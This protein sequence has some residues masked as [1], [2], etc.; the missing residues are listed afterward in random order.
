MGANVTKDMRIPGCGAIVNNDSARTAGDIHTEPLPPILH[1]PV[2]HNTNRIVND[3]LRDTLR[4]AA[5]SP[6]L[7]QYFEHMRNGASIHKIKRLVD[8]ATPRDYSTYLHDIAPNLDAWSQTTFAKNIPADVREIITNM[9]LEC[10]D[11]AKE[12]TITSRMI[13][14]EYNYEIKKIV[15]KWEYPRDA[16]SRV[17]VLSERPNIALIE[18]GDDFNCITFTWE[19]SQ[20]GQ[21]NGFSTRISHRQMLARHKNN[22]A[23]DPIAPTIHLQKVYNPTSTKPIITKWDNANT[24]LAIADMPVQRIKLNEAFRRT[25]QPAKLYTVTDDYCADHHNYFTR[26][27]YEGNVLI[28]STKIYPYSK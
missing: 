4:D 5:Y 21:L 17:T 1:G 15:W 22:G 19:N 14:S 12:C 11:I 2:I 6:F 25:A 8:E 23:N 18:C 24:P 9:V 26:N 28:G 27:L 16:L 20:P 13:C 3:V 10:H 7:M